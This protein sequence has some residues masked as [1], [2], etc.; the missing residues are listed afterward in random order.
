[1]AGTYTATRLEA[2]LGTKIT[3]V[4]TVKDANGDPK[5]LTSY[6]F[7]WQ[8]EHPAGTAWPTTAYDTTADPTKIVITTAASGIVTV[9]IP[10]E[11][12]P[13]L[14]DLRTLGLHELGEYAD[15]LSS[16]STGKAQGQ[17]LLKKNVGS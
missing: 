5:N 2:Y 14:T 12:L 16:D 17:L 4:Y 8:G 15:G 3:I 13:E 10:V 6:G 9:T 11:D 7:K 1:M